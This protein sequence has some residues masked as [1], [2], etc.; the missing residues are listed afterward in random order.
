MLTD[1]TAGLISLQKGPLLQLHP[2]TA[3]YT[4]CEVE[5]WGN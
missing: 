3:A 2:N 4:Q 1:L 5:H